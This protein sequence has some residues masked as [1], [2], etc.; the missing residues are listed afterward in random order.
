I[1]DNKIFG[2][3]LG[4]DTM[5]LYYNRALLNQNNIPNPPT[6]WSEFKD[7]VKSL[8]LQD[9]NG[10]IIQ[11]GVPLGTG[12][13]INRAPDILAVLMLQNG[14]EMTDLN[15]TRATFNMVPNTIKDKTIN[16]GRDALTF[17]TDFASPAK[18]VYTW[19]DK[20]PESLN[21]FASQKSAFFLGYAY[22]LPLIRSLSPGLD[23]GIAKLPQISSASK[24]VNLANYW[25][26]S[27]TKQ[28]THPNEAWAF[29][30]FAASAD[31][32]KT[33][34]KRAQKPTALRALIS[35]QRLDDTLITWADQILTAQSWYRGKNPQAAEEA[36][37]AMIDQVVKGEYTSEQA[38]NLGVKKI[39]ETF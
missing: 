26:E 23:L 21:A 18:E 20:M 28:S 29:V 17:Y 1:M 3:P 38:I 2:L 19:N 4:L 6:T 7:T 36:F 11:A 39:N 24:P 27:V 37:R 5:V 13:N 12:R 22:H 34:L 10:D 32:V 14:T 33:F 25:I 15:N 30:Q 35:E 9:R 31:N 8:V 16:P